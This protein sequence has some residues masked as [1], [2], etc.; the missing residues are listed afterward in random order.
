MNKKLEHNE[1]FN[2][3]KFWES[4]FSPRRKRIG[5]TREEKIEKHQAML[6]TMISLSVLREDCAAE[7]AQWSPE[8][9]AAI[10]ERVRNDLHFAPYDLT[11]TSYEDIVD[12]ADKL[13]EERRALEKSI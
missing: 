2:D 5:L 6:L 9:W 13:R 12:F 4:W 3:N 7:H 10:T 8:Y 11:I 1:G